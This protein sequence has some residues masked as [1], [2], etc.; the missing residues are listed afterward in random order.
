[1]NDIEDRIRSA[2]RP[3]RA[4]DPV[5][6]R[7]LDPEKR[8]VSRA[9]RGV[10]MLV[11][12][13]VVAG[14]VLAITLLP[15]P[16]GPNPAAASLLHRFAHIARNAAPESAPQPG[17]FVYSKTRMIDSRVFV[18]KDGTYRFLIIVPATEQRWLGLDGS[19]RVVTTTGQAPDFPMQADRAAYDA[20]IASGG[21]PIEDWG[22]TVTDV[23]KPGELSWRDTS[24]L[25][26][27]P[28]ALGQLI[29]ER[30]I[31]SGPD[32]DWESFALA[33]DLLRDSYARPE[34]RAALYTYMAGLSGIEVLGSTTDSTGRPGVALASSH[35]GVRYEVV[36]DR[37]TGNILEER[38]VALDTDE[39]VY[40][41][42][43]PGEYAFAYAGDTISIE[44]Y[45]SFRQ[46]VGSDTQSH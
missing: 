8:H 19:G 6:P 7:Q 29:E 38:S 23:Y 39:G 1:M 31:V 44:T 18:S 21:D 27:D 14:V 3:Y 17:Q 46:V 5:M 36:F 45:V 41:N 40:N 9:R 32:G 24:T 13:S 33:T 12:T 11:L 43:G 42:P 35:D 37:K 2:V 20:Y 28:T 15:I 4:G 34:L 10:Q 22:K 16:G 25:P 30:Q 26:T